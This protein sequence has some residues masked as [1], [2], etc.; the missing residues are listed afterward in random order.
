[1]TDETRARFLAAIAAQLPAERIAEVHLFPA[2]RQGGM[3]SGVAVV[4]VEL[5]AKV[6]A[7]AP[8]TDGPAA[9]AEAADA[10]VAVLGADA[11]LEDEDADT[12]AAESVGRCAHPSSVASRLL[13]L[14]L[15][16]RTLEEQF[17]KD[18]GRPGFGG[19]IHT[20]GVDR[21]ALRVA[22]R[23]GQGARALRA[24]LERESA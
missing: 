1:M 9:D 2:I 5:R 4:A 22:R 24:L 8:A 12:E 6:E 10:Q 20:A 16:G 21:Q 17:R 13:Q 11:A 15:G 23:G 3:E 14:H 7:D 19:K 18:P